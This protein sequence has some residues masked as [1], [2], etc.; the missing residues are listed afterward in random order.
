MG[1]RKDA[2]A[3]IVARREAA[4]KKLYTR[5]AAIDAEDR[6]RL[7]GCSKAAADMERLWYT[8]H[9]KVYQPRA[10]YMTAIIEKKTRKVVYTVVNSEFFEAVPAI[11]KDQHRFTTRFL[12]TNIR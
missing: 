1:I 11:F 7:D 3:G 12:R 6:I 8:S 5:A 4:V 10:V 9:G 2:K